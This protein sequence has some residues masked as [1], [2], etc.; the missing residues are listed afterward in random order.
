MVAGGLDG[1]DLLVLTPLGQVTSGVRVAISRQ[2]LRED[3]A[4]A[5]DK[6]STRAKGSM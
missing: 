3:H 6:Y 4:V 1:G 5:S 2:L